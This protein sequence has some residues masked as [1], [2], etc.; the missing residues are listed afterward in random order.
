M[1]HFRES[2]VC[3]MLSARRR[4]GLDLGQLVENA[5]SVASACC[6]AWGHPWNDREPN[7]KPAK[8]ATCTRCGKGA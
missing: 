2:L 4:A 3:A 7:G 1:S 6:E 5:Q 8:G